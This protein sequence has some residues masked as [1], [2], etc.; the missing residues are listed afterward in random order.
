[1]SIQEDEIFMQMALAEAVR[2][3]AERLPIP[4]SGPWWCAMAKWSAVVI[5]AKP[6]HPTPRCMP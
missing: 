3:W 1:M 5:T 2:G 6:A 4:V